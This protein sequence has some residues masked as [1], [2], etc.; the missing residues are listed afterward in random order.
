MPVR[1]IHRDDLD[2]LGA[3]QI[4]ELG[5]AYIVRAVAAADDQ[6]VLVEPEAIATLHGA[7]WLD[8]ADDRD[9]EISQHPL[10]G[11]DL[12]LTQFLAHAQEDRSRRC[13]Q[14]GI[15]RKDGILE[16]WVLRFDDDGLDP[17]PLEQGDQCGMLGSRTLL[18]D[19]VEVPKVSPTVWIRGWNR[20][21]E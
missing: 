3:E 11:S 18:V 16:S 1:E 19:R 13:D 7:W 5:Y 20:S 6:G 4:G 9:A 15:E 17:L 14:D 10:E 12:R 8:S 2:S 21:N